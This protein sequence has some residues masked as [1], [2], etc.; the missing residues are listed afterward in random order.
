MDA[1]PIWHVEYEGIPVIYHQRY[2]NNWKPEWQPWPGEKL[3]IK[4][5]RPKGVKGKTV[6]IDSST[7][8]L[9]P[10]EQVT[11]AKLV[12]NLRSSLGGQHIIHLPVNAELQTVIINDQAM[13]IGNTQ[14]GIA[15]PV[16]PG[17]Q[18]IEINWQEPR[19]I[20]GLYRSSDIDLGLDSVNSVIKIK[21]G[22][23]RWLLFTAGPVMG[24][25]ILFWGMLGVILIIAYG[26][27]RVKDI[28]LNTLQWVLL[29]MGLSATEPWAAVLIAGSLL[30]LRM[31]GTIETESM[32]DAKFKVMQLGLVALI[33]LSVSA[34]IGAIEQGLLGSPDMQIM[35]NGSS[36]YQLNWFSD[37]VSATL[38]QASIISVPVYGY[39][40]MMLVWSIW[41]AFAL[42][43]WAQWGWANYTKQGYWREK[44]VIVK[45]K[46]K[47]EKKSDGWGDK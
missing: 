32:S 39:R 37:R 43:K 20:T 10:G 26:L 44:K 46:D 42:I 19:G 23:N 38:P 6:T 5:T 8:T 24:P 1:S 17:D 18:N 7:L 31:R 33:F 34:M 28:P 3:S 41:L 14:E 11:S 2:G 27:G 21:P 12:F 36:A 13:P 35:G 22:T 25:A 9:S 30:A 15:L 4:V 16:L 29:G 40:L 45:A 47:N